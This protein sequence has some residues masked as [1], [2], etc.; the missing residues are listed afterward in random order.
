VRAIGRPAVDA[1]TFLRDVAEWLDTAD[2]A[3]A[4]GLEQKGMRWDSTPDIQ[5]AVRRLAGWFDEHPHVDLAAFG[6]VTGNCDPA[7]ERVLPPDPGVII[8]RLRA[9]QAV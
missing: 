8:E 3:I 1:A 6:A 9:L 2:V 7:T 4:K 5:D